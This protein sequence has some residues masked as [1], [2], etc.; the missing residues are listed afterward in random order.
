MP[1]GILTRRNAC[2][3]PDDILFVSSLQCDVCFYCCEV[4]SNF[5][6]VH[7]VE[8]DIE[9]TLQQQQQWIAERKRTLSI[10]K[11]QVNRLAA[12][13]HKIHWK[14]TIS[15]KIHLFFSFFSRATCQRN[16]PERDVGLHSWMRE[17]NEYIALDSVKLFTPRRFFYFIPI[18]IIEFRVCARC[19]HVRV[20]VFVSVAHLHRC[21]WITI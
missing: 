8:G 14:I 11:L 15:F 5:T 10:Y 4:F 3:L 21:R 19:V 16:A 13:C 7:L 2:Y 18:G 17:T 20:F 1:C 9:D 6:Y 12:S